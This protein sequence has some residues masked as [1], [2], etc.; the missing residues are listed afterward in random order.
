MSERVKDAIKTVWETSQSIGY[1]QLI[2]NFIHIII[3]IKFSLVITDVYW[4]TQGIIE[5]DFMLFSNDN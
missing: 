2:R 4:K 5:P 3:R 1:N